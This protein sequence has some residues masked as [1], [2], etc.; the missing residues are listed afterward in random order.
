MLKFPQRHI[1]GSFFFLGSLFLLLWGYFPLKGEE[2]ISDIPGIGQQRL[3]WT[4]II[5]SGDESRITLE[6]S[7]D[8][9]QLI[10]KSLIN[11]QSDDTE[12]ANP[13]IIGT[14]HHLLV[15]SRIEMPG[16]EIQPNEE[17]SQPL[18]HSG[19]LK[20]IWEIVAENHENY[21]GDVWLYIHLIPRESGIDIRRPVS[22]HRI[23]IQSIDLLGLNVRYVR[24]LA[25]ISFGTALILW[26]DL[27]GTINKYIINLNKKD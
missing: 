13:V 8:D 22:I 3:T 19:N 20:F 21:S 14:T 18:P 10:W 2:Q 16:P 17:I 4:P 26:S 27:V 11:D 23:T 9:H 5:R 24:L 7:S 1:L 15:E 6:F 12:T 25:I